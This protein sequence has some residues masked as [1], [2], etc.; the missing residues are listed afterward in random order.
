MSGQQIFELTALE[1]LQESKGERYSEFLRA[2]AMSAG[3]YTLA[4]DSSDP[5]LPHR[6]DELYVVL[7]GRAELRVDGTDHTVSAGTVCYVPAAAVHRFHAITEEL[8]VLVLFA[9]AETVAAA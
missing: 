4:P 2:P 5:Q 9:P 8:R 6:E 7:A 1:S 3:L